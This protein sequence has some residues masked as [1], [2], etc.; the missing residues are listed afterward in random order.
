MTKGCLTK[1][2]PASAPPVTT[3][4]SPSGN[5]PSNNSQNFKD[6][7]GACSEFL[8]MTAFPIK[9]GAANFSAHH[10]KGRL[11]ELIFKTTPYGCCLEKFKCF[12][13]MEKVSPFTSRTSPAK[14]F[15]LATACKTSFLAKVIA[16]PAL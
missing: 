16:L 13:S 1:K 10:L 8:M 11:K 15:I 9:I 6:E 7:I 14:Y 3:L 4:I 2:D 5:N 12:G